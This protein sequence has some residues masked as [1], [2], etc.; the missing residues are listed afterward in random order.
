MKI[1]WF[2]HRNKIFVPKLRRTRL[3]MFSDF[4]NLALPNVFVSDKG[5]FAIHGFLQL[6]PLIKSDLMEAQLLFW[7]HRH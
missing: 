6:R 4:K 2:F 3:G 1:P 7:R 5:F